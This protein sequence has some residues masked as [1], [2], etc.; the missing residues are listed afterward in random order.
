LIP[1]EPLRK[2]ESLP[3]STAV[4]TALVREIGPLDLLNSRIYRRNLILEKDLSDLS[5]DPS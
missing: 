2:E 4:Y 3:R 5:K 1:K